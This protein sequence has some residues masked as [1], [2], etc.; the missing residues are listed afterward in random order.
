MGLG[1]GFGE[2][3][4]ADGGGLGEQGVV[5][6]VGVRREPG[7]VPGLGGRGCREDG[8]GGAFL[9]TVVPQ[10]V[11]HALGDV[12]PPPWCPDEH[13]NVGEGAAG[14]FGGDLGRRVVVRLVHHGVDGGKV[15]PKA[16]PAGSVPSRASTSAKPSWRRWTSNRSANR[17]ALLAPLIRRLLESDTPLRIHGELTAAVRGSGRHRKRNCEG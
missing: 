3:Q 13:F 15:T 16:R 12:P 14:A 17:S 5:P 1:R 11:V 2:R 8:E 9:G 6:G 7:A 4:A 10:Q